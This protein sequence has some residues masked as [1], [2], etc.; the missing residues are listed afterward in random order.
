MRARSRSRL[1]R[2]G[3]FGWV[4]GG[5][6]GGF[7]DVLGEPRRGSPD[8]AGGAAAGVGP[9]RSGGA[10]GPPPAGSVP[11]LVGL[12]RDIDESLEQVPGCL[13]PGRSG[14]A[15][16]PPPWARNVASGCNRSARLEALARAAEW[17]LALLGSGVRGGFGDDLGQPGGVL[18]TAREGRRRGRS[19]PVRRGLT[20]RLQRG[21]HRRWSTPVRDP[22][23]Q[24]PA[25]PVRAVREGR[26]DLLLGREMLPINATGAVASGPSLGPPRGRSGCSD[27]EPARPPRR[28]PHGPLHPECEGSSGGRVAGSRAASGSPSTASSNRPSAV[29]SGRILGPFPQPDSR[30]SKSTPTA[31]PMCQPEPAGTR[32]RIARASTTSLT[33][34]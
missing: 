29:D 32:A 23:E 22:L 12:V 1:P 20:D 31:G 17:S 15:G 14:G 18:R 2:S 8:R 33:P 3:P 19:E 16:G 4:C 30:R 11:L 5:G 34:S 7:G 25:A 27:R 6:R 24:V 13:G 21:P 26:M 9:S 28:L 10:D